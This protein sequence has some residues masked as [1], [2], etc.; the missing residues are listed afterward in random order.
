MAAVKTAHLLIFTRQFSSMIASR[1]QLVDIL[2][3]LA[4][5]TPQRRLR[6]AIEN[7]S[8]DVQRGIDF[9][10]A[11]SYFHEYLMIFMSMWSGRDWS[12]GN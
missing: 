2:N 4:Q 3:N 10:D 5:E 11:L 7:I 9:G 1:L 12:R 8:N 6:V